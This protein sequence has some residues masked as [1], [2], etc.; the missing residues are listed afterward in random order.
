MNK[1]HLPRALTKPARA[2]LLT[3]LADHKRIA[4][5]IR[6]YEK[7]AQ[8]ER[9]IAEVMALTELA[10]SNNPDVVDYEYIVAFGEVG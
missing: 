7:V 5:T 2:R 10:P 9:R 8:L 4:A 3:W 6:L 1:S